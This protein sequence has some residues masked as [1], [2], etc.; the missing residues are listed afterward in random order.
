MTIAAAVTI[1]ARRFPVGAPR[2]VPVGTSAAI[3]TPLEVTGDAALELALAAAA[4]AADAMPEVEA[5]AAVPET[6]AKAAG[7]TGIGRGDPGTLL[8]APV[9]M[10]LIRM[11][12]PLSVSRF[13]LRKSVRMSAALW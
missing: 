6:G 10:G 5:G 7:I 2:V 1:T 3:P 8:P 9:S 13:N 12:R 4:L 11:Y